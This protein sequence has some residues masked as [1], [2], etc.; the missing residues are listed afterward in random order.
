MS[1][2]T[3]TNQQQSMIS[4]SAPHNNHPMG[5]G[6]FMNSASHLFQLLPPVDGCSMLPETLRLTSPFLESYFKVQYKEYK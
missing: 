2:T 3:L 5:C 1:K 4:Q 6:V